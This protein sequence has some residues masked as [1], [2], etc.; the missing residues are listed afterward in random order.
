MTVKYNGQLMDPNKMDSATYS[1]WAAA[2]PKTYQKWMNQSTVKG[3]IND[4]VA[5]KPITGGTGLGT[6]SLPSTT[7]NSITGTAFAPDYTGIVKDN[8]FTTS[9]SYQSKPGDQFINT[10]NNNYMLRD[11]SNTSDYGLTYDNFV[12]ENNSISAVKDPAKWGGTGMNVDI[13]SL[14]GPLKGM[15]TTGMSQSAVDQLSMMDIQPG[16]TGSNRFFGQDAKGNFIVGDQAMLENGAFAPG[17]VQATQTDG[18]NYFG[19]TGLNGDKT[20]L[21]FGNEAWGNVLQ[22]GGLVLD[23]IGLADQLKTNKLARQGMQTDIDNARTEAKALADYRKS[24][25][26]TV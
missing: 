15:N 25:G 21:G 12:G 4:T 13:S 3:S 9:M 5:G 17:S 14:D 24:Y 2:N 7:V 22:G 18:T 11:G 1:A 20:F 8:K 16:L 19:G 10:P 23:G 26:M 6:I